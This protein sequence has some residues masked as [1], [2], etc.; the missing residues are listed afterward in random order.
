MTARIKKSHKG[1]GLSKKSKFALLLAAIFLLVLPL[2]AAANSSAIQSVLSPVVTQVQAVFSSADDGF[3]PNES[4]AIVT[5]GIALLSSSDIRPEPTTF[6]AGANH[7]LA[8]KSDGTLWSWGWNGNGATGR[9]V[10]A[11]SQ[12]TPAQVG[13]ATNWRSVSAGLNHSLGLR[14][15]GSLWSWG[16]NGNG[17]TGLNTIAGDQTTPIQVGTATNWTQVSAGNLHSLGIRSDGTLWAWGTNLDGR[18]GLGTTTGNQ[19][20]PAQV[21]TATN[22]ASVSAGNTH[23]LAIASDGTLWAWGSNSLGRT[24]LGTLAGTQNTPL[25][26]GSA[27]DWMQVSAATDHSLAIRSDGT[28]WAWGDNWLGRTGL[29]TF[30]GTQNTPLQVGSATNW[31][32]VSVGDAHSLAVRADGTLW[33]W[34][35]N[36]QGRTGLGTLAGI[37]DS[38]LQVGSAT[39]WLSAY[40]SHNGNHSFGMRLDGTLWAWGRNAEGQLGLGNAGTGTDRSVPTLVGSDIDWA[41]PAAPAIIDISLASSGITTDTAEV[42]I[43]FDRAINTA[44]G[45]VTLNGVPLTDFSWNSPTNTE[46]TAQFPASFLPLEPATAYTLVA[47]DFMSPFG[48]EVASLTHTFITVVEHT[49]IAINKHLQM[50]VGTITPTTEFA[51]DITPYSFNNETDQAG[52]LPELTVPN[53]TF[54]PS[55]VATV[56]GDVRTVT[57]VS[58][59]LIGNNTTFLTPGLF[60][61][62]IS[63]RTDTFS[64][65]TTETMTFDPAI[66]QVTFVVLPLSAGAGNYVTTVIVNRILEGGVIS[67]K[68]EDLDTALTFT[69]TFVRNVDIDP[70][71]PLAVGGLRI[72]KTTTGVMP[73][74]SRAFD[75]DIRLSSPSLATTITPPIVYR[76][77]IIN[78]LTNETIGSI[79]DFT[80]EV[81]RTVALTHNQTLVFLDTHVGTRYTAIELPVSDYTPHVVVRTDGVIDTSIINPPERTPNT[82]LSTGEQT[83]GE[84]ANTADFTNTD[85]FVPPT[86]LDIGKFGMALLLM[87]VAG[88]IVLVTA[89]RR[90]KHEMELQVLTH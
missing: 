6:S 53:I 52:I 25:Q 35:D 10:I 47:S 60:T 11:G 89:T 71:D 22:W 19:L 61:Y 85:F 79:I 67:D 18:T 70:T 59:F 12:N 87:A 20:T 26:V 58:D 21:G 44:T 54:S 74:P 24:G 4:P 82:A 1:E 63:E 45:T 75:F 56:T 86:G 8:I 5:G 15:D 28:L 17:K 78:T 36:T 55:D 16:S 39:D 69:N 90:S 31:T 48:F 46:L 2:L 7:S 49:D 9:G 50:P 83:L 66:Y 3:M 51:F 73:D 42:T 57:K 76:A 64:N 40:A 27:T 37:Q 80:D 32:Q 43:T 13:T 34:G 62:R 23:S 38:P 88:L 29:G 81:T 33:A 65:T 72:S 14:A 84:A 30:S 68:L 77:Q 41:I